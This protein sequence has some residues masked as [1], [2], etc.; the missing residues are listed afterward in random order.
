MPNDRSKPDWIQTLC[1]P[2]VW[3]KG[4]ELA[5]TQ[6]VELEKS[7]LKSDEWK[8]RVKLAGSSVSPRVT[9]WPTENDYDCSCKDKADPCMHVA[10]AAIALAR[11]LYRTDGD[12]KGAEGDSD[13][14]PKAAP[15]SRLIYLM[16]DL[17]G[18]LALERVIRAKGVDTPLK[19]TLVAYAGGIQSG[20]I[21]QPLPALSQEDYRLDQI[22]ASLPS[23]RL[24]EELAPS[25]AKLMSELPSLEWD[26][27]PVALSSRPAKPEA[28]IVDAE[29]SAFFFRTLVLEQEALIKKFRNGWCLLEGPVLSLDPLQ[30]LPA[31]WRSLWQASA[32]RTPSPDGEPM[33]VL[34]ERKIAV[35]DS[36]RWALEILPRFEAAGTRVY[37][38]STRWPRKMDAEPRI[39]LRLSPREDGGLSVLPELVYARGPEI[40]ARVDRERLL[41]LRQNIALARDLSAEKRWTR[42][43]QQELHLSP[44]QVTHFPGAEAIQFRKRLESWTNPNEAAWAVPEGELDPDFTWETDEAL[45]F[46]FRV[47]A[48]KAGGKDGKGGVS[49]MVDG[50]EVLRAWQNG[51]S[52]VRLL[53]GSSGTS[54]WAPIPQSWLEK[55]G[56]ALAEIFEAQRKLGKV[57][58]S[59]AAS[60]VELSDAGALTLKDNY[61]R[62]ADRLT[63]SVDE[64]PDDAAN[65]ILKKLPATL[66]PLLR[67][68][69]RQGVLWLKF[70]QSTG[71]GTLLADDMGLGKTIQTLAALHGLKRTLIVAPT[72][73]IPAWKLQVEKFLPKT[74]IN[75]YH[76]P[77]RD[78][79]SK[80]TL[81]LT[82]YAL[83]RQDIA[84]FSEIKWDAV[85]LDEAQAIKNPESQVARAATQIQADWRLALSGTPIENRPAE[86][87]SLFRFLEPELL[88]ER[89]SFETRWAG[90]LRL[91][92]PRA[93]SKLRARIAPFL[94]RRKKSQVAKELPPKTESVLYAE[95]SPPER[96]LYDGLFAMAKKEAMQIL[97]REESVF[98]AL[99]SLLRLRQAC[100]HPALLNGLDQSLLKIAQATTS[101]KLEILKESLQ[102]SRDAGHRVLIFSQWTR[103]LDLVEPMLK[104]SGFGYERLDG[105]TPASER[106]IRVNR[107]QGE[108]GAF[109]FLLSLKAGGTGIT[110][111]AADQ[112]YLLDPWWNPFV[113][114]QAADRAHRIGQSLPVTVYRLVARGTLEE[115]ILLLQAEKRTLAQGLIDP[116]RMAAP[117]EE[118]HTTQ[119]A[120]WGLKREDIEKLLQPL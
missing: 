95:L 67:P 66:G 15:L 36:A 20:R 44:G 11:D 77:D 40:F 52:F 25:L 35:P 79:A 26:G 74:T 81:T 86:L 3:S 13:S 47:R 59:L 92:D 110:L 97:E 19:G 107:F 14:A 94:L 98:N 71:L 57:P 73:V 42:K 12:R 68:Y 51:E 53:S 87:W 84:K 46:R 64:K 113:E 56:R 109:A 61:K 4:V 8:F 76:G 16:K 88:G 39:E 22:L 50:G 100:C 28:E 31:D 38:Q 2:G 96:E 48:G 55:H 24:P 62:L 89:S 119:V 30:G 65:P 32:Q 63:E 1:L 114:D 49:G 80:S 115:R 117:D 6:S 21:S 23:A 118:G 90:P 111:T 93:I 83:L 91:G 17:N 105:T 102:A 60:L 72:S 70:R 18:E 5:R 112:V 43:L 37:I 45:D 69:Q 27:T 106:E 34:Q 78:L 99:E 54:G 101:A 58:K 116:E 82:T 108:T 104:A 29:D 33:R 120:S 41:P 85:V 75:V 7:D 9:L 103:L 10:A